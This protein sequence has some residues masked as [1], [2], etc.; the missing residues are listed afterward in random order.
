MV[1]SKQTINIGKQVASK[2]VMG[3]G[4]GCV[5][6]GGRA[7]VHRCDTSEKKNKEI[8]FCR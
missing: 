7:L 1:S 6:V 2:I 5:G 4:I 3:V 8:S